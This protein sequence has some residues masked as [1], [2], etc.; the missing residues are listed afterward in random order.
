MQLPSFTI[1]QHTLVIPS[2]GK[3]VTYRPYVTKEEKVLLI[4]KES[5]DIQTIA[6]SLKSLIEQCVDGV[7]NVDDL[8][9]FDFEYIFLKL[10]AVSVQETVTARIECDVEGCLGVVNVDININELEPTL[11]EGHEKKIVLSEA[12]GIGVVMKYPTIGLITSPQISESD[13]SEIETTINMIIGC[14]DQIFDNDASYP[15]SESTHEELCAFV[16]SLK[17]SMIEKIEE[18]FFNTMP[19]ISYKS[20]AKCPK[21]GKEHTIS[22][23]GLDDFF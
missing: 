4:A 14:I 23:E 15:A 9:S 18:K 16:D 20:T 3:Q 12:D 7:G 21:C 10:R 19:S 6:K 8:T 13:E 11:H 17:G 2:T 1:P 22:L 5:G